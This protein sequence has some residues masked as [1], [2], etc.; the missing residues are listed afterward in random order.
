[1]GCRGVIIASQREMV[2]TARKGS[3]HMHGLTDTCSPDQTNVVY[4]IK[5]RQYTQC[6]HKSI[7][8]SSNYFSYVNTVVW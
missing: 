6:N 7:H 1:M 4:I 8:Y 5:I 2:I 3:R